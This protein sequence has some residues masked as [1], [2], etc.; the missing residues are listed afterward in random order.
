MGGDAANKK[1]GSSSSFAW[2]RAVLSGRQWSS[3]AS[4]AGAKSWAPPG[5]YRDSR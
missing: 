2:R 5:G 1:A 4:G 3:E